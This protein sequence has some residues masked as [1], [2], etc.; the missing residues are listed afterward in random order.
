MLERAGSTDSA[1]PSGST[2]RT[3]GTVLNVL[4]ERIER[5]HLGLHHRSRD[6]R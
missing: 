5:L 2:A 3:A 4:A 1:G 6:F